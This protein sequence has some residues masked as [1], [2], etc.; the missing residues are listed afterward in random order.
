[1]KTGNLSHVVLFYLLLLHG[2][3]SKTAVIEL[4]AGEFCSLSRSS[5]WYVVVFPPT[6]P[7]PCPIP[8]TTATTPAAGSQQPAAIMSNLTDAA[9]RLRAQQKPVKD[10]YRA[11]ALAAR[12]TLMLSGTLDPMNLTCSLALVAAAK[13]I[14]GMH[15]AAG[16]NAAGPDPS[17]ELC[18]GDM[19]LE[20]LVACFGVTV[21]A[22]S[23]SMGIPLS[24]GSVMAEG[25][26]EFR[27]TLGVKAEDG[28]HVDVGFQQIW[29]VVRLEVED[30]YQ[31]QVDKLISLSE[32]YCVVLQTLRNGVRVET[33]LGHVGKAQ[34]DARGHVELGEM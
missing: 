4:Y 20:S 18:S 11:D 34:P 28:S 23:T 21:R 14:A 25:D 2:L 24:G 22:V 10:C 31:A 32:R 17:L 8:I 15:A 29:L 19:L 5:P 12:V 13:R 33:K 26:L 7:T 6:S 1:M 30:E 3:V 27:G 16:G 9:A